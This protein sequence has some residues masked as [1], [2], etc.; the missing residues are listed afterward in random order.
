ME[1]ATD[2]QIGFI[3]KLAVRFKKEVP[4]F[5]YLSKDAAKELIDDWLGESEKV[6]NELQK[7]EVVRPGQSMGKLITP[8]YPKPITAHNN[9][10]VTMYTSYAKDIFCAICGNTMTEAK[11]DM[12]NAI[13]LVKQ[14]KEAFE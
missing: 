11:V 6:S 12:Q 10:H 9:N 1:K 13:D 4:N 7:T 14:A 5:E 2:K 8:G 3:E